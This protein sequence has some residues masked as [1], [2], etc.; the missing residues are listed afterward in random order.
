M[1][2]RWKYLLQSLFGLAAGLFL[3]YTADAPAATTF[4]I[5]FFKTVALPLASVSFVA[6]RL[7]RGSSA[8]PTR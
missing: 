8:S 4:Y 3:Y 5:P 1:K 6:H 7:L 2:S